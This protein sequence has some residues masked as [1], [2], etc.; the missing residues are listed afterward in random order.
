MSNILKNKKARF[1]I[2]FI[3]TLLL[4]TI[5]IDYKN[6]LQVFITLVIATVVSFSNLK[7]DDASP[8]F[9][10]FLIESGIIAI[11]LILHFLKI[12]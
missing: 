2:T 10:S 9:K 3:S 7:Y 11:L 6:I 8:S 5:V 4:A 12:I 1:I